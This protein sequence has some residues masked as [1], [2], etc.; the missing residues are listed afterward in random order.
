MAEARRASTDGYI[1]TQPE[2]YRFIGAS[3]ESVSFFFLGFEFV[4]FSL[5]AFTLCCSKF[6]SIPTP[7]FFLATRRPTPCLIPLSARNYWSAGHLRQSLE[8][9]KEHKDF[10]QEKTVRGD[11]VVGCRGKQ[12]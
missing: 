2:E 8:V 7:C 12:Q 6:T 10:G 5:P 1:D 3:P 9:G 11:A 4:P